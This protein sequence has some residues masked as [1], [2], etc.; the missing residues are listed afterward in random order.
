MFILPSANDGLKEKDSFIIIFGPR[1]DICYK[2]FFLIFTRRK[3]SDNNTNLKRT[4]FV[5]YC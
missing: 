4:S 1:K 2:F 3:L 5:F